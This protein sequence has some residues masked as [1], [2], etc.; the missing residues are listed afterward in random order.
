MAEKFFY[1]KR[2]F[3]AQFETTAGRGECGGTARNFGIKIF[4]KSGADFIAQIFIGFHIGGGK[5][6]CGPAFF[7]GLTELFDIAIGEKHFIKS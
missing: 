7:C 6:V 1:L 3:W 5:F 2:I 4:Q